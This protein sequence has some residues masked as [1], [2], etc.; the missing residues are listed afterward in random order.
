MRCSFDF[1]RETYDELNSKVLKNK[2]KECQFFSWDFKEFENMDEVFDMPRKRADMEA[3]YRPWYVGWANCDKE[4]GERFRDL[5]ERPFF[6]PRDSESGKK[7]WFF[8]GT[9]GWGAPFHIDQVDL[10][11]WQAQ[12]M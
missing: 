10:P 9:P 7:D 11:S 4:A 3:G 6:L 5:Y 1:F 2:D 12:V 8:M